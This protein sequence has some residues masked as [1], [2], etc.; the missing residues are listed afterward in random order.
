MALVFRK[1]CPKIWPS[2]VAPGVWLLCVSVCEAALQSKAVVAGRAFFFFFLSP[3][4]PILCSQAP[5]SSLKPE[6]LFPPPS[7]FCRAFCH[8]E[9]SLLM[10]QHS[11]LEP[12]ISSPP[13]LCY[14]K[15]S[16]PLGIA[17]FLPMCKSK[18]LCEGFSKAVDRVTWADLRGGPGWGNP[19]HKSRLG[20]ELMESSPEEK[21]PGG[22]GG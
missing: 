5:C 2:H 1:P 6:M 22:V 7:V 13:V 21:R 4:A 15:T 12:L 3:H 19:K 11:N 18:Q 20:G 10:Q 14:A 8:H 16:L 9:H 17:F